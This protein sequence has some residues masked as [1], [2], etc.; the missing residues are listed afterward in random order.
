VARRTDSLALEA[1]AYHLTTDI[2]TSGGVLVG[3]LFV[4]LTG[5]AILDPL[6]ALG[7]A[8]LIIRAAWD[9]TRRS[10]RDL[11]DRSLPAEE[12]DTVER[13]LKEHAGNYVEY[14]N[15]R[16][17]KAGAHRH[18]DLHLVMD[19]RLTVAQAHDVC[20]DLEKHIEAALPRSSVVIHVEPSQRARDHL[21]SR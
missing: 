3:L 13:I 2:A 18:I 1:D 10:A 15:L 6:V 20:E 9:I 8:A 4:K 12:R 21:T 11:L 7:V 14:H 16:S 19:S 5:W 17:R